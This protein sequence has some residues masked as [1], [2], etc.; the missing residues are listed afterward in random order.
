MLKKGTKRK[1]IGRRVAAVA[2]SQHTTVVEITASTVDNPT[3]VVYTAF[4]QDGTIDSLETVVR[5]LNTL[6]LGV[7]NLDGN[8]IF[9]L[10]DI[11][12]FGNIFMN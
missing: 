1:R 6:N 7:F 8:T 3:P 4:N 11:N 9:I 2:H 5:L 10:D 12:V